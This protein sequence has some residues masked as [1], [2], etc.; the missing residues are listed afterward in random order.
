MISPS[1]APAVALVSTLAGQVQEGSG[2]LYHLLTRLG[3]SPGTASDITDLIVRPLSILVVVA[4]ALLVAHLG[5]KAIRRVLDR[6]ASQA[7]TR[8]G[9][10]S[11][12][13]GARVATMSGVVA[14]VWRIFV[15]VVGGAIVLGM[16]GVDLTPL[17][18]SATIIGATLG[19]GAQQIVRDY[20]SGVIMTME[21]QYNVGDAVTVGGVT[22]TIEDVT[23]RL[24]RFRGVDGTVYIVP[25]GDIRLV[26]NLSRGWARAVVDLTL[27]GHA[28][29]DLDE[30]RRVVEDAARHVATTPEFA[31]HCTEP[32]RVVGLNE[33]D[34]AT[35]TLR[36]MLRTVPSQRD[37]LTRALREEVLG[38]LAR[39]GLWPGD[40][41]PGTP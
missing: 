39:A 25:N 3:V 33:A 34:A 2:W 5:A 19:F 4:V 12:R 26:G 29:A 27:P 41:V 13:A 14:N 6:V 15:F 18:A 24:T 17:L 7:A 8:A 32:P 10:G 21:D 11:Q 31:A 35:I 28:A 37:A 22:G 30:V 36:V 16:L 9:S 20:F 1:P 40:V 38:A 23:M